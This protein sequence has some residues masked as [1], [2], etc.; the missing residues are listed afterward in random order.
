MSQLRLAVHDIQCVKNQCANYSSRNSF[1][2]IIGAR[3][4]EL[5]K[6]AFSVGMYTWTS[7]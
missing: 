3:S 5:A 6:E 2:N 1:D 7:T 4:E